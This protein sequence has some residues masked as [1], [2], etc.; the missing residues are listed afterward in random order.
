VSEVAQE[1]RAQSILVRY[2]QGTPLYLTPDLPEKLPDLVRHLRERR[3]LLD[4]I[5]SD[6]RGITSDSTWAQLLS[7]VVRNVNRLP[8]GEEE[9]LSATLAVLEQVIPDAPLHEVWRSVR[10]QIISNVDVLSGWPH[11]PLRRVHE[12]SPV[13]RENGRYFTVIDG[14]R[15]EIIGDR[16]EKEERWDYIADDCTRSYGSVQ[17]VIRLVALVNICREI[18]SRPRQFPESLLVTL[19]EN[20]RDFFS[21]LA[22]AS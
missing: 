11:Y 14:E 18:V 19:P 5:K 7:E 20:G 21:T 16:T 13:T 3:R 10:E 6:G 9:R 4:L 12:E 2:L 8:H 15:C 1:E 22:M 17:S